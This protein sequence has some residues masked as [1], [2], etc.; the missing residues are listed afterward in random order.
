[1]HNVFC[2]NSTKDSVMLWL[3]FLLLERCRTYAVLT[4]CKCTH[5]FCPRSSYLI[6]HTI[7]SVSCGGPSIGINSVRRFYTS[8]SFLPFATRCP[9]VKLLLWDKRWRGRWERCLHISRTATCFCMCRCTCKWLYAYKCSTC[10][11]LWNEKARRHL[12]SV[13]Q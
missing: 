9:Q 12:I 3:G 1:M 13:F 10:G 8:L 7:D 4:L 5:T 2:V 11:W 6:G